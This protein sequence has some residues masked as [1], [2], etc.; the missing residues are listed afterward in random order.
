M[1]EL[2]ALPAWDVDPV[3]IETWAERLGARVVREAAETWLEVPSHRLRGYAVI[4]D[5]KVTAINFEVAPSGDPEPAMELLRQAAT[6][7]RWE[8]HED[9]EEDEDDEP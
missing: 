3:P 8:L 7:L 6:G 5:G 1:P 9:D 4:E 2:L